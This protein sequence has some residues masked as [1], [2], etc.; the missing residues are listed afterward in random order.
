MVKQIISDT[1]ESIGDTFQQ[2]GKQIA[3]IPF[4]IGK[5]TAR[6]LGFRPKVEQKQEKPEQAPTV[7]EPKITERKI[8]AQ[9]RI[10][11]LEAEL[12]AIREQKARAI[13]QKQQEEMVKKQMEMEKKEKANQ[14]LVVTVA[15]SKASAEKRQ[16]GGG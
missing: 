7:T 4:Q 16:F 11:E 2:T 1:F 12:R 13:P 9:K 14:P 3:M 10:G 8:F 6:Q 15:K 5:E